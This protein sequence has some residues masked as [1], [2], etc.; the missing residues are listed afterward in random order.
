MS[1]GLFF[2]QNGFQVALGSTATTRSETSRTRSRYSGERS[3][4]HR[5]VIH[6]EEEPQSSEATRSLFYFKRFKQIKV[7]V[8]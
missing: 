5:L 1:Y 4:L 3:K 7:I 2:H 6:E 8:F